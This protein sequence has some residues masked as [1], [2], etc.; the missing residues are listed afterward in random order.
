MP[1]SG[2][3]RHEGE[4]GEVGVARI[5][6]SRT[7][8]QKHCEECGDDGKRPLATFHATAL[9]VRLFQR[10]SAAVG[11]RPPGVVTEQAQTRPGVHGRIP[12]SYPSVATKRAFESEYK[13]QPFVPFQSAILL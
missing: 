11:A 1:F 10:V 6:F 4:I 9:L 7:R 8:G 3:S 5:Q 12:V 13:K 2:L